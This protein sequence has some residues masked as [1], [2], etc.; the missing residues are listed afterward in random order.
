MCGSLFTVWMLVTRLWKK[1]LGILQLIFD[2]IKFTHE[3]FCEKNYLMLLSTYSNAEGPTGGAIRRYICAVY[4]A[5]IQT[6]EGGISLCVQGCEFIS[7][8]Q[9][10]LSFIQVHMIP[11]VE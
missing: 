7:I 11:V 6:I 5:K 4:N 9:S 1:D 10:Y 2:D 3:L 8:I